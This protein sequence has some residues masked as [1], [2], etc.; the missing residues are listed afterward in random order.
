Q[1]FRRRAAFLFVVPPCSLG[2]PLSSSRGAL[3]EKGQSVQLTNFESGTPTNLAKAMRMARRS[4]AAAPPV[5]SALHSDS[6]MRI[7]SRYVSNL[8]WA[9]NAIFPPAIARKLDSLPP[10]ARH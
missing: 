4:A 10:M 9:S 8:A 6:A 2:A 5:V 7:L 1:L 3:F